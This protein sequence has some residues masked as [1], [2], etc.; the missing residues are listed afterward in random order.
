MNTYYILLGSLLLTSTLAGITKDRDLNH[1][2]S[3]EYFENLKNSQPNEDLIVHL[4]PHS[5]DD[6]G[7]L[8]SI[9]Q[10]YSGTNNE[11]TDAAVH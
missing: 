7:W 11:V 2:H 9:D 10:Y 5:H 1:G 4:I 6:I 3:K 8:K